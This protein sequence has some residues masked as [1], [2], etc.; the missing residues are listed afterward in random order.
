MPGY[1]EPPVDQDVLRQAFSCALRPH[2]QVAL[3]RPWSARW[4]YMPLRVVNCLTCMDE[5]NE[6]F[7]DEKEF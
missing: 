2:V 4:I 7:G 1:S 6:D 3:R 5:T